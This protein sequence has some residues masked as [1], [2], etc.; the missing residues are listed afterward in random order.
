M[1]T[2]R[3]AFLKANF[4]TEF[5]IATISSY[6]GSDKDSIIKYVEEA[7]RIG[8]QFL[9]PDIN[10]SEFFFTEV[11]DGIIR[12]G[13]AAINKMFKS[14]HSVIAE[15][16][17]GGKYADLYNFLER[18]KPNKITL[19]A[20]V[21]SGALDE[22]TKGTILHL[23]TVEETHMKSK[24]K[25]TEFDFINN[26]IKYYECTLNKA[27]RADENFSLS[28]DFLKNHYTLVKEESMKLNFRRVKEDRFELLQYLYYLRGLGIWVPDDELIPNLDTRVKITDEFNSLLLKA[29][30]EKAY[31]NIYL[32]GH[33]LDSLG[34][35]VDWN[36]PDQYTIPCIVHE[37]KVIKTK[38][39]DS[40]AF[41]KFETKYGIKEFTIFPRIYTYNLNKLEVGGLRLMTFNL[42]WEDKYGCYQHLVESIKYLKMKDELTAEELCR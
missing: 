19:D 31:L 13:L 42:K 8:I 29:N 40:M 39:G 16:Q 25:R 7:R 35:D 32:S 27:L 1:L 23:E 11:E 6:I 4:P 30:V 5:F 41:A 9:S 37:V 28:Y 18:A 22:L 15:R 3:T 26:T 14:A 24:S 17:E 10:E 34:G 36:C 12:F 38:K 20:L 33:P 21:L 2:I